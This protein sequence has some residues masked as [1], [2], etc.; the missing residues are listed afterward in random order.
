MVTA[1]SG[2]WRCMVCDVWLGVLCSV[3]GADVRTFILKN[4]TP[5][6]ATWAPFGVGPVPETA[7]YRD[8][9]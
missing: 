2:S 5:S 9:L 3:W 1:V 7:D 4:G 6:L 8:P